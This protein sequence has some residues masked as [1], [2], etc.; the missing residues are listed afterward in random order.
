MQPLIRDLRMLSL[1]SR[2]KRLSEKM[3]EN[4]TQLYNDNHINFNPKWFLA[5]YLLV[6]KGTPVSLS[7]MAE[8]IGINQGEI[9]VVI[10]EMKNAGLLTKT[11]DGQISLSPEGL[12][13]ATDVQRVWVGIERATTEWT[14]STGHD[15]LAAM[16]KLEKN[17]AEKDIYSRAKEFMN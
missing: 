4:A 2:L 17:F 8:E 13:L 7:D 5:F 12:K 15:I 6:R 10:M 3:L 11:E 1:A 14:N 9:S 16:E